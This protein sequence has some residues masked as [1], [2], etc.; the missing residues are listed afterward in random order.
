MRSCSPAGPGPR[1][2]AAATASPFP[3]ASI[4]ATSLRTEVAPEF[5]DAFYT[6]EIALTRRLDGSYTV[7]ISGKGTLEITPQGLRYAR[8]FLPMFVK[9]LKAVELGISSSF[10]KGPGSLRQLGSSMK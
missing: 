9:R 10:F 4:R 3:Q 6:P 8:E 7:A 1:P 5:L 2:S